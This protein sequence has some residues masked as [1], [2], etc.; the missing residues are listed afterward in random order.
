MKLFAKLFCSIVIGLMCLIAITS[1]VVGAFYVEAGLSVI[2]GV[3]AIV[4]TLFG[5]AV[6]GVMWT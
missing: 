6:I 5:S 1:C 3:L 4:V 2:F